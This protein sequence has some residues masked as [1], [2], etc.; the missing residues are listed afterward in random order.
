[1]FCRPGFPLQALVLLTSVLILLSGLAT[2]DAKSQHTRFGWQGF[3]A[4]YTG[5]Y[6]IGGSVGAAAGPARIRIR[7]AKDGRSARVSW[8]NTFYTSG[9]SHVIAMNWVFRSNGTVTVSTMDP[10]IRTAPA[11]GTFTLRGASPVKFTITD[12]SG[13]VILTGQF[14]LI[15]GGALAISATLTGQSEGDIPLAFSGSRLP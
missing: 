9:G 13:L 12:A 6:S 10:R 11:T 7:A 5:G 15:G 14:R 3:T 2:A 1:M 4:R 8:K